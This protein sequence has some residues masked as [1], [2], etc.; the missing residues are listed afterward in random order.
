MPGPLLRR[1]VVLHDYSEALG[2]AS[3]LVQVLIGELRR[4]GLATTFI[5]GDAGSRF[6][7]ADVE[8]LPLH[9]KAL[10]ERSKLGAL[11]CGL[12]NHRAFVRTR[13]WIANNDTPGTIYHLHGWSKI[14][15]PAI[16][17]ALRQV[18]GRLIL[19]GH[20]YFN[21]CPNGAFFD[22]VREQDC[23]VKPL[24][25]ACLKSRCDKASHAQKLWR[26]GRES[27][28]RG[29]QHGG[30]NAARLLMI[31]PGQE[32]QFR[33]SGWNSGRLRTVRNPVSPLSVD[34]IK[35]EANRG[36]V[37]IGRISTEKGADLAAAAAR[38]SGLPI[39][40]VGDGSEVDLVRRR[41]P[42]AQFLGRQD[43]SGVAKA[44]SSA[45]VA[46]MP[47]R[48]SEPFGLVALEAVASGVPVV[49]SHR[50]LVAEEIS[51]AGFGLAVNTSDL[52]GFAGLLAE[53]DRDDRA[54]EAM[55]RAGQVGYRLL[56]NSEESWAD[57]VISQYRQVLAQATC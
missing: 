22:Y 4:R 20:D 46:V 56:C 52:D 2:G 32:A 16:F 37:F 26:V 11:T 40:F 24:G 1:V 45:R 33:R 57:E 3:H 8:F 36:I 39:T 9:G 5:S 14:L 7:R 15:T 30:T 54:V 53:L 41:N 28:R 23:A 50:A 44:L 17:A 13:E 43:R 51:A 47:S 12:Y 49:V 42:G 19:H 55:S 6:D 48:W 18:S 35:A 34:R 25:A 10:L 27:L 31:H 38:R 21:G 29:L